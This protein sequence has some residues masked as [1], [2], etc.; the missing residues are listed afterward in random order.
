MVFDTQGRPVDFIFIEVNKTFEKLTGLK[1]MKGKRVTEL[2]PE[3]AAANPKLF[4]IGG[5]VSLIGEPE[6]T[7]IYL[8]S[9]SRWFL[10]SMYSLKKIFFM[11]TFE[12]ITDRKKADED[13][14]NAK[15]AAQNVLEDLTVEESKYEALAKDLEKFKLATDN[16]AD[17][18]IITDPEGIVIYVN[19]SVETITGYTPEETLGKKSGALWRMPM[20]LGYYQ[21]L[22][23]TI[24][25]QKKV[26]VGEIQ[27]RRKNGL[28]YTASISISPILDESGEIQFFVGIERD[29]TKEKEI[30]RAKDEFVSLASHQLRTPPSIIGWYTET[31]QAGDLGPVNER[32]ADY[33]GE[34]YKANQRMIA[35]I[36]SLLNISRIE[37]GTFAISPR[38][39]DIKSIIDETLKE[40]ASRFNRKIEVI[41]NY[42]PHLGLPK[43]DPNILQ[44]IIDNLLSNSFKYSPPENTKIEIVAKIDNNSLLLSVKDNGIGI[45]LKDQ[46]RVFEKLFR[47]DNAVSVNPDGTGLGLYMIKKII[48]DGLGGKIWFDSEENKGATFYLSLP[49]SGM[50]EKTGTTVLSRVVSTII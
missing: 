38:E 36:N 3:I 16:A 31:L 21:S 7:E 39:I 2:L 40:L 13:L 27:N 32:Q 11:A 48:V 18:I 12:D 1:G 19:K 42:D 24:K 34:I 9:L 22:W 25:N 26:F 46:S 30:D 44:I 10:V 29:M 45:P 28:I 43:V 37:M 5:R 41:K 14:A 4:E 6:R 20:T 33:L 8:E 50:K 47:A 35:V 23:D 49:A 15:M 17:N